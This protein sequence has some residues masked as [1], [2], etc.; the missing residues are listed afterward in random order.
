MRLG[1]PILDK[2]LSAVADPDGY[3]AA[4]IALGY[5]AIYAPL[6]DTFDAKTSEAFVIAAAAKD[7]LIAE[8]GAWSNPIDPAPAKAAAALELCQQR[9]ELAERLGATCCVNIAGSRNPDKWDAPHRDNLTDDTFDLIVRTTRQIIDAVKPR[10]TVYTLEPMPWIF[11][12]SPESYL[13][14]LKAI[15]RPALAVHLDPVN[16]VNC[17]VRAYDTAAFLRHCFKLL[18]PHIRSIHAK[19]VAVTSK[20]LSHID[21]VEPGLGVLD[22]RVFL[23]EANKLNKD[24]PVMLEHLPDAAAYGRA[25]SHLRKVAD[26]CGITWA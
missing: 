8:V 11:P 13:R 7:I 20:L 10:R 5:R 17:H 26:E 4:A 3:I 24:M 25:A 15:D 1:G 19:D 23:T 22:Y 18:G 2:Q 16:M 12:D 6:R 21:E 9:L 14:L